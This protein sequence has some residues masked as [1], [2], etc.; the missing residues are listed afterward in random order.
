M[1]DVHSLLNTISR[2]K[3]LIRAARIGLE[4]YRRERDLK[5]LT[6]SNRLPSHQRAVEDLF[7]QETQME[8]TRLTGDAAYSATRHVEVLTALMAEIRFIPKLRAV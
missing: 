2:P 3:L 6:R 1:T 4:N 8:Q 5:R 7:E